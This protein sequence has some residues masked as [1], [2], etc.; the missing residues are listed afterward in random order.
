MARENGFK[1][2][3]LVSLLEM[4]F[5]KDERKF[6]YDVLFSEGSAKKVAKA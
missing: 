5:A 4:D 6:I 2:Y 1:G 3:K